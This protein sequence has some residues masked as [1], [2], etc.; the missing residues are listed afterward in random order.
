MV[1]NGKV[2]IVDD[3]RELLSAL[4]ICL[5]P[6]FYAIDLLHDPNRIPEY[7]S[8][9]VYDLIL[10]DMNFSRG[11][12]TGNEGIFWM[13]RIREIS[14]YSGI[15]LITAYGDV[16]LAV[17]AMREGAV[18]FILKSWDESK[19]IST[20]LASLKIQE[21]Q[22]EIR[23]LKEKGSQLK[24]I[25][26]DQHKLYYGSSSAMKNIKKLID[27]VAGTDANILIL[28]ENGTG[29]ELVAREIHRLSKRSDDIFVKI[30]LGSV[31]ESLFE[32]ELFGY[33]KGAFTDA[34]DDKAGRLEVASGGTVFLDEIGNLSLDMQTKLL[35]TLQNKEIVRV[36]D[37]NPVPVD[38]RIVS[39]TNSDLHAAVEDL[40]FRE[41]LFY[42]LNTIIIN[43]PPLRER[44]E[45]IIFLTGLFLQELNN[46]YG[47]DVKL[48]KE[49]ERY[50]IDHSWPGNI[51]ELR[52]VIEKGVILAENDRIRESDLTTG[53]SGRKFNSM[54]SYNLSDNEKM[55]IIS[56]L[57]SFNWNI[58][59]TARELG[60]NRSTL[61]EKISKYEISQD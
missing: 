14:P 55:I 13:N 15:V 35:G 43:L 22:K 3:N 56:A 44:K 29:K 8:Q 53:S 47:R 19:I 37:N 46:E 57:E 45:D 60:I 40:T 18:D 16:S 17:K 10:L 2:L 5:A 11:Q 61:Y 9:A 21:S 49:S 27:K 39:A 24:S 33:R 54:G 30:D 1:K 20:I 28:G 36:G 52:H 26:D 32:S 12:T 42:R 25:I 6:Y 34:R 50:L 23:S 41:D 31:T 4:K 59:R 48:T 38:I 51:R 7:M 58:S